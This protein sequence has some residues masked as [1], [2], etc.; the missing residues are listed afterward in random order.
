MGKPVISTNIPGCR[1]AIDDGKT[2]ILIPV[3]DSEKLAEAIIYLF[4]N[5]EKAKQFGQAGREKIKREFS[6]NIVL[7]RIE[8]EYSRLVKEKLRS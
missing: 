6:G 3:K 5:P 1:E 2:G 8:I 4:E 7:N